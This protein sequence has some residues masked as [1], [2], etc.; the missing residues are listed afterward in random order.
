ME[1]LM[2]AYEGTER[3][4]TLM[5]IESKRWLALAILLES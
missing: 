4:T 5:G 1:L 3:T 2:G